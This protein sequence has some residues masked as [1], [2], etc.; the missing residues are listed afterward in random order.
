MN[1][2]K[3]IELQC[4][5]FS[6]TSIRQ[7][8]KC[9]IDIDQHEVLLEFNSETATLT[10]LGNHWITRFKTPVGVRLNAYETMLKWDRMATDADITDA[11][12]NMVVGQQAG[13]IMA[14]VK[15]SIPEGIAVLQNTVE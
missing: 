11:Q 2:P 15:A 8:W 1:P 12:Y 5:H 13:S 9:V 7:F 6:E 14:M 10:A 3:F 4:D